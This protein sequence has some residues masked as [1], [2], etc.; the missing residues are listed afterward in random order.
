[1]KK[2]LILPLVILMSCQMT[3]AQKVNFSYDNAGNRVKREIALQTR[4]IAESSSPEYFSEAIAEKNIRI[5]PNP[6]DGLL[7]VEIAGQESSDQCTFRIFNSSG[8]QVLSIHA[9]SSSTV[10]DIS[11]RPTGVY[12]LHILLNGRETTWKIIKK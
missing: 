9:T 8:L 2:A 6:T 1:M 7:R 10:L 11:A 5:Y 3:I 12:I 4:G